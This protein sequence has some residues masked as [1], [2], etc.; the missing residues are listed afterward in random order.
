MDPQDNPQEAPVTSIT[1]TFEYLD[2]NDGIPAQEKHP[3]VVRRTEDLSYL[4]ID[5]QLEFSLDGPDPVPSATKCLNLYPSAKFPLLLFR[6]LV[7]SSPRVTK[8]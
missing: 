5:K 1:I 4:D 6:P 3:Y 7:P 2:K 8:R